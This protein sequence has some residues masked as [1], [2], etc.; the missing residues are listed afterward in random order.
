MATGSRNYSIKELSRLLTE[1]LY[2]TWHLL[3]VNSAW[4]LWH[5]KYKQIMSA[6]MVANSLN[7]KDRAAA[8]SAR[9]VVRDIASTSCPA[10]VA[11]C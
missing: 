1:R 9:C 7:L 2:G 10:N 4:W 11:I 6:T 3:F 5:R 8:G